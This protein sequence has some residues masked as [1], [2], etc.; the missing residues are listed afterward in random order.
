MS[1]PIRL[2]LMMRNARVCPAATC[3]SFSRRRLS[4]PHSVSSIRS[5]S[6]LT[7]RAPAGTW[8]RASSPT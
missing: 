4:L 5:V 1:K 3:A 6:M 8:K 7:I 2:S